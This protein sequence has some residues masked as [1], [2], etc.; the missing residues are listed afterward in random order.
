MDIE[1]YKLGHKPIRASIG[2]MKTTWSAK[3]WIKRS[4]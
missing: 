2:T 4:L 1:E 3:L